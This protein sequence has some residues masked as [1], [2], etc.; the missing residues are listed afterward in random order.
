VKPDLFQNEETF[1]LD[2]RMGLNANLTSFTLIEL[3]KNIFL[4]I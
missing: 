3:K 2:H 4:L 1:S